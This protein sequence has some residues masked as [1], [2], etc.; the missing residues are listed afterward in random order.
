MGDIFDNVTMDTRP[1]PSLE[2]T[3]VA[4]GLPLVIFIIGLAGNVLVITVIVRRRSLQT[5]TNCYLLS[6]CVADCILLL[7]S[8]LP[9]IPEPLLP[10]EDWPYGS[11]MCTLL[12]FLGY[13]GANVS[14]LSIGAFTVERYIGICHSLKAQTICTVSRARRILFVLWTVAVLYCSPWLALAKVVP[15][16]RNGTV[17]HSCTY[18]LKRRYYGI[19]YAFDFVMFYVVP[20]VLSSVLY[21]LM[22]RLLLKDIAPRS[23]EHRCLQ[24]R[25]SR[26]RGVAARMQVV[27]MLIVIV[28]LFGTLWLPY[29]IV[30]VYNS[31]QDNLLQFKD[32]W[33][34][35]F[36]RTMVFI[37]SAINPIVYNM[38]SVK[39]RRAFRDIVCKAEKLAK[40]EAS[41]SL[42]V[43]SRYIDIKQLFGSG[44]LDRSERDMGFLGSMI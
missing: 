18:T 22:I 16:Y 10:A 3:V 13:L 20:L 32:S 9:T 14:S 19:Y 41:T 34:W 39:F 33:F 31:F 27:R 36:C 15:S 24:G 26:S 2:Y 11:F 43:K 42:D 23:T 12:V 6:L 1:G 25:S 37:N 28:V 7:S 35:L 5:P 21:V 40:R 17:V 44:D 30:V 8:N 38:L 29:R 4:V